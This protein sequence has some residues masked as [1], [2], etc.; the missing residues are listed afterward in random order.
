[1]ETLENKA[2]TQRDS[3]SK[4]DG[5]GVENKHM[6]GDCKA[7][8]GPRGDKSALNCGKHCESHGYV[9]ASHEEIPRHDLTQTRLP[10]FS[11]QILVL[12][13]LEAPRSPL[14]RGHCGQFG[15]RHGKPVELVDWC[16]EAST[17]NIP[18]GIAC[19]L[20]QSILLASGSL[21]GPGA[22]AAEEPE[23]RSS[24]DVAQEV[25]A[26]TWTKGLP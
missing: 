14:S 23:S 11:D 9:H 1:M 6:H 16:G 7:S 21:D 25:K 24:N 20:R 22:R 26:D 5:G 2:D 13:E 17:T 4:G 19:K 15:R 10:A 8:L 3:C 12:Q 18:Q